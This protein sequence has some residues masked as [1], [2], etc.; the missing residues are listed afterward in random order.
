MKICKHAEKLSEFYSKHPQTQ[1]LSSLI[2]ISHYWLYRVYSPLH[3]C[4]YPL[5][6]LILFWWNWKWFEEVNT[7]SHIGLACVSLARLYDLFIQILGNIYAQWSLQVLSVQSM[8]GTYYLCKLH[9]Q[10]LSQYGTLPSF[11]EVSSSPFSIN[12]QPSPPPHNYSSDFY[13]HRLVCTCSRTFCTWILH[14][15]LSDVRLSL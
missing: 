3:P 10:L 5:I 9:G 1:H 6:Y 8:S 14:Y 13:H 15:M 12:P 4:I 11:Q 7:L 2:C